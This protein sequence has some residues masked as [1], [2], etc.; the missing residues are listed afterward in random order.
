MLKRAIL[1]RSQVEGHAESGADL[2]QRAQGE[3][4]QTT[5]FSQKESEIAKERRVWLNGGDGVA[6]TPEGRLLAWFA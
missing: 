6:A 4:S 5:R 3:D 2:C 1:E